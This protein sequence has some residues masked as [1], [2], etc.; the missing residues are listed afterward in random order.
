MLGDLPST[1]FIV[2]K[3][4]NSEDCIEAIKYKNVDHLVL[5]DDINKV[6]LLK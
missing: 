4:K 1:S 6:P 2:L 5:S 3:S